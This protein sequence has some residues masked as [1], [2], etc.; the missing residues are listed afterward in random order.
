MENYC[1]VHKGIPT[2]DTPHMIT[3]NFPQ[4]VMITQNFPQVV[5]ITQNFPQV[6]MIT[7]HF[8]QAFKVTQHFTQHFT[9]L[10]KILCNH[11]IG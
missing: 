2:L 3:Q 5:M 6:V 10:W 8:T 4:V 9:H 7:Q 11:L 1:F